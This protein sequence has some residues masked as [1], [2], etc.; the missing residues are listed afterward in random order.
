MVGDDDH[1]TLLARITVLSP[2]TIAM[3][4]PPDGLFVSIE[5]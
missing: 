1:L 3:V 5:A 2:S 4:A